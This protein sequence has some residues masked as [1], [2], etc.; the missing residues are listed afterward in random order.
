MSFKPEDGILVRRMLKAPRKLVFDAWTQPALMIRWFFPGEDWGADITSNL[1]PGG[2]YR[3]AMRG[4]AG[5]LHVQFGTWREIIP[6]EVLEFSWNCP[7]LGV[8]NSIVRVEL[9]ERGSATELV[10]THKL[11]ADPE[12]R[13]GHEE[14]WQGCLANLEKFLNQS[15]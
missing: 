12:V 2:E 14:G 7:D 3:I 9:H 11:P 8:E 5:Q 15:A 10:L 13:A 1:V 6:P 4:P